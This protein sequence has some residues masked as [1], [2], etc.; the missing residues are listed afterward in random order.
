MTPAGS[1]PSTR[2]ATGGPTRTWEVTARQVPMRLQPATAQLI[3][4]CAQMKMRVSHRCYFAQDVTLAVQDRI[5][6]AGVTYEVRGFKDTDLA[7]R[8]RVA[9]LERQS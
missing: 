2:T 7:E 5:V 9:W 1:R 6:V 8:L 3:L 4:A